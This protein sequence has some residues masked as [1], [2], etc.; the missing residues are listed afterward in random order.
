MTEITKQVHSKET[1]GSS[2]RSPWLEDLLVTLPNLELH[3]CSLRHCHTYNLPSFPLSCT[4]VIGISQ[5]L[6]APSPSFVTDVSPNK[7][8]ACIILSWYLLLRRFQLT[9]ILVVLFPDLSTV[10][11]QMETLRS[12]AI[13]EETVPFLL[14]L[15]FLQTQTLFPPNLLYLYLYLYLTN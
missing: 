10:Y 2:I 1:R 7:F 8:L 6:L 11:E 12:P 13:T 9:H 3:C 4:W 15:Q 5:L 14:P